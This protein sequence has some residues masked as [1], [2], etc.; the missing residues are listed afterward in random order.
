MTKDDFK[1]K[2]TKFRNS[3]DIPKSW[4]LDLKEKI[5]KSHSLEEI[6]KIYNE[7]LKEYMT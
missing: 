1:K 5:V 4:A 7:V 2:I 6:S 3:S